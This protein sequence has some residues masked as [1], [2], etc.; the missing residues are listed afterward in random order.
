[1]KTKSQ[2]YGRAYTQFIGLKKAI[3][4]ASDRQ[5][6]ACSFPTLPISI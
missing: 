6:G 3:L 4:L 5:T 1:M 2:S